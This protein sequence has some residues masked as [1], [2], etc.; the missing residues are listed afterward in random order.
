MG[1][2]CYSTD[3]VRDPSG[4]EGQDR[5]ERRRIEECVHFS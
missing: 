2:R 5:E 1:I 4:E 3:G